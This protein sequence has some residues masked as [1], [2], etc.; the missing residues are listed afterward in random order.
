[1]ISMTEREFTLFQT[2]IREQAAISLSAAK[3]TLLETRLS[4]RVRE[5][6]LDSFAAYYRRV[7][8][9]PGELTEMLDRVST[10]ETHFFRQP[11]Q[12]EFLSRL[13]VH[14]W[15]AQV[16]AGLR[17]RQ[18]RAWSAGCSSGEEPYSLAMV[19]RRHFASSSEWRIEIL[20]TDLS[21][22]VLQR[23]RKGIWPVEKA[24]DIP[25]QYLRCFMLKGTGKQEGQMKASTEI[26]SI[27]RF[28][29]LNLNDP[30]YPVNSF[31]DLILCR[32]VLIYFDQ[33]RRAQVAN[34]L[35]THLRPGGFFLTGQSERLV[36][37][38]D[39]VMSLLPTIYVR[40]GG[41]DASTMPAAVPRDMA[42]P[43]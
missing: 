16:T 32:N 36:G 30:I 14:D 40:T 3:K 29:R 34:R 33:E 7:L 6:G 12:F 22:R 43:R 24:R 31:F 39:K 2:L 42:Q 19:L 11:R 17:P 21:A 28:E 26:A 5:L 8:D 27:I 13:A 4:S 38:S 18:I 41:S 1:M 25:P 23:A 35:L 20:A 9:G 15:A 10:N 37:M